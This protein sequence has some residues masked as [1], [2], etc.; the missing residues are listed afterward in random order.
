[1]RVHAEKKGNCVVV[2][3]G[4]AE[5][6][7]TVSEDFKDAVLDHYAKL[8]AG[9]LLLDLNQVNFMDSKAIG[10]MVAVRKAVAARGGRMGICALHPHVRKV[11]GVV[12]LGTIFDIFE[13]RQEAVSA[14]CGG[15]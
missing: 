12:T 8:G 1:M 2:E 9:D 13:T 10:A 4:T 5:V 11:V 15:A 3:V 6:N 14:M 7:L